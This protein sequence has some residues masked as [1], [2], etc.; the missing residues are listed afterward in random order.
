MRKYWTRITLTA[1]L[2]FSVG[3]GLI[4]AGRRVKTSIVS[5]QDI[6]IPLGSFIGFKLD[7]AR[8]GSIRSLNI[9]RSAPKE[10]SGFDIRVRLS[11][12]TAFTRLQNCH[13]S[14]N[15]ARQIDERTSFLCLASDSGH[16]AFGEVTVELRQ[17]SNTR[18]LVLPLLLPDAVVREFQ[19]KGSDPV[20][21]NL[22]DSIALEVKGRVRI[23]ARAYS[24]S[25]KAAELD[26]AAARYR[27]RADSLRAKSKVPAP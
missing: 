16:Q 15:D 8:V 13:V 11:D 25:V 7:G 6:T 4:A 19:R 21:G 1:L 22:A 27:Q 10:L 24:D 18:T 12:S 9:R 5:N 20:G 26:R 3:Y 17:D 14:V 2:I 23:Q